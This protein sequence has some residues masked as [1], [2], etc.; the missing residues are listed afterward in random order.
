MKI[1]SRKITPWNSTKYGCFAK[2]MYVQHGKKKKKC[3]MQKIGCICEKIAHLFPFQ[4]GV[5]AK[6]AWKGVTQVRVY[7]VKW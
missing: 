5:P 4:N 2:K 3:M 7:T 6:I 1:G